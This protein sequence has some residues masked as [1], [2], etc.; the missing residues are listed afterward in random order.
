MEVAL[1]NVL[2]Q[3]LRV[4]KELE[5]LTFD[6]ERRPDFTPLAVYRTIDRHNDGKIDKINLDSFFKRNSLYLTERELLALIRRIDT[7][8]D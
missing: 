1:T 2:Q 3:E 7:S 6:I 4:F 5:K 8:A